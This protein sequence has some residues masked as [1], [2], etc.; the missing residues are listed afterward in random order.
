MC[1]PSTRGYD[2]QM[3]LALKVISA[4]GEPFR[5][6]SP[7]RIEIRDTSVADAPAV[8]LKQLR[9]VVPISGRT[10]EMEVAMEVPSVPSGTTVWVHLDSDSDG[11]VSPGDFVSVESFPLASVPS[12]AVTIRIK[13][14]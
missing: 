10:T 8:V 1:I 11:R 4:T 3:K 6:G 12:Q 14:I 13:K 5:P 2:G 7:M 9:T